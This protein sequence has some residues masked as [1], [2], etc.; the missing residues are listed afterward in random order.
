MHG[1]KNIKLHHDSV[2]TST[3]I[4]VASFYF[5]RKAFPLPFIRI[6]CTSISTTYQFP[7]I[8]YETFSLT[9]Q[10]ST[11]SVYIH[12][13]RPDTLQNQPAHSNIS[14]FFVYFNQAKYL[15]V[16]RI[17]FPQDHTSCCEVVSAPHHPWQVLVPFVGSEGV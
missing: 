8:P 6:D 3:S 5:L 4:S 12:V 16:R 2:Q 13:Q 1:Q 14:P 17:H 11:S 15:L 7:T 10:L 9:I